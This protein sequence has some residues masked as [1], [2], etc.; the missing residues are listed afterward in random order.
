MKT[1][2]LNLSSVDIKMSII[3]INTTYVIGKPI[4]DIHPDAA[5]VLGFTQDEYRK[6]MNSKVG[7]DE[8][9]KK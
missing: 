5:K 1:I 8:L 7:Y 6:I 2:N 9:L 3:K 4:Y